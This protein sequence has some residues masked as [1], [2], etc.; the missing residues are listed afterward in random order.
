MLRA[1][2]NKAL[3]DQPPVVVPTPP[4]ILLERDAN[5]PP[6]PIPLIKLPPT[7]CEPP[8]GRP[9]AGVLPLNPEAAAMGKEAAALSGG[10]DV[11]DGDALTPRLLE[12]LASLDEGAA[13]L[14]ALSPRVATPPVL[15]DAADEPEWLA[16]A[17]AAVSSASLG[18]D[19]Q[20]VS[21]DMAASRAIASTLAVELAHAEEQGRHLRSS[22]EVNERVL[23]H[24]T[25]PRALHSATPRATTLTRFAGAHCAACITGPG[26]RDG[27]GGVAAGVDALLVRDD[28]SG[29][30]AH[31]GRS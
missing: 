1:R 10:A 18:G 27:G 23:M 16:R 21:D 7:G 14:A 29:R 31:R 6:L 9:N 26:A 20:V 4:N 28:G 30:A 2:G 5:S 19:G 24:R 17:E 12:A 25:A 22:A 13:A 11:A 3:S 15:D 8:P